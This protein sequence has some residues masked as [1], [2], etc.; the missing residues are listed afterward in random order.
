MQIVAALGLIEGNV[1]GNLSFAVGEIRQ[2]ALFA[3]LPQHVAG[4][5][6]GQRLPGVK[7]PDAV[8]LCK[9]TH[10]ADRA[11]SDLAAGALH[12]E[13]VAGFEMQFFPQRLGD[14]DDARF[15]DDDTGVHF[16]FVLGAAREP[17]LL[18]TKEAILQ[19]MGGIC[20]SAR[21][22]DAKMFGAVV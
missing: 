11:K 12:F 4:G 8:V 14:D 18:S 15:V 7:H 16:S 13:G 19:R 6:G 2:V 9:R 17:L 1:R 22:C 21:F 10:P 5:G 3:D 20:A